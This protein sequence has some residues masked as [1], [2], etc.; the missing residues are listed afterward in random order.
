MPSCWLPQI[1]CLEATETQLCHPWLKK[2]AQY[3]TVEIIISNVGGQQD[4]G[5][6]LISPLA[7][8]VLQV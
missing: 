2:D 6:L 8:K 3:D 1:K 5:K 7:L 4:L